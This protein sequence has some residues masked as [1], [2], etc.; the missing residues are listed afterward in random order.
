MSRRLDGGSQRAEVPAR[1]AP[2]RA[3]S[4][5]L[6][7][8]SQRAEVPARPAPERVMNGTVVIAGAGLAGAR[9]AENL[10]VL[11]FEGRIVLAG[12]EP[13]AP[14]ERP[15]LS[16][17]FLAG[18]RAE[19]AL[20]P[21][22]FWDEHA[23]ELHTGQLVDAVDT[24]R[25]SAHV[26]GEL[27]DWDAFVIATGAAARRLPGPSGVH[28]LRTIDDATALAADL[29]PATRLVVVGAGFIG[30]EVASTALPLVASV[31]VV[32][33]LPLPLHRILGAEVGAI[34]ADRYRSHGV[35]LRLG[36]GVADFVGRERVRGVTLTDGT[37]VPADAVV[38]G[39][40]TVVEACT[41]DACGRTA[42]PGVYA[43]GD[44][45]SWW[46]P[47]LGRHVR[48][49]HW[50]SAAGQARAVASAIVGDP[51]PYDEPS[52]FWSDQFGLRLQ[53]V[54]HA[55]AWHGVEL[56]GAEDAFTARYVDE[57]GQLLAALAAN[58]PREL[59]AFRRAL[60]A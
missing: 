37:V 2:E 43:C 3:M 39:I 36:V 59:A 44:V 24:E 4:R 25:R 57:S 6:D 9:C 22:A 1:P 54:G 12:A 19:L 8:G 41:V 50:T 42:T 51:E 26:G 55:E 14:Y 35:D 58:R 46:R 28:H 20:R 38:V 27:I 31:T 16:K 5:R 7:G 13:H 32:E 45:A 10:R 56:D 47:S 18:R 23:I 29:S 17:E 33:P 52:F 21:A 48:V 49:E 11:G 40:G 34:L 60:A 15:A 53:H 30:G